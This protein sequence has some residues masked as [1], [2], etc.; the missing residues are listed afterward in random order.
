MIITIDGPSGTGKT[1]IAKRVAERL[2]F[3]YFDTG[4]MYRALTW[5]FL[6][7]GIELSDTGRIQK[8]LSDFSFHTKEMGKERHY[9][10]GDRDVTKEIR[11]QRVT[12]HVSAVSALPEVRQ[13]LLHIQRNFA[14]EESAVFEGRDL[15][16]VVFP[17]AEIKV[18][19]T[20]RPEV[21]A[22][23][24]L[25]EMIAKN[26]AE[27]AKIDHDKMLADIIRRDTHDSTKGSRSPEMSRRS[28][29]NRHF[30]FDDR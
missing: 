17:N 29:S 20:A 15:G 27:A 19:L 13:S 23:R 5:L 6:E 16:T 7:E 4:A 10:V 18:F 25:D 30:Q 21:R 12:A 14:R 3:S 28:P 9:F 1:T 8:I 11:S 22:Q 2:R 24:R 26:P